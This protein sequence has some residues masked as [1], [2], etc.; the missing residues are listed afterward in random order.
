MSFVNRIAASPLRAKPSAVPTPVVSPPWLLLLCLGVWIGALESSAIASEP[1]PAWTELVRA[2]TSGTVSA[3]SNVR[4]RFIDDV[5]RDS[6]VGESLASGTGQLIQF[7]PPIAGVVRWKSRRELVFEPNER[8]ASGKKYNA[9]LFARGLYGV[10]DA[11]ERFEFS[12]D[13]VEQE[14]TIRFG[15]FAASSDDS[16]IQTFAGSF[17]TTDHV[18]NSAIE[19]MLEGR[20]S[21]RLREAQW[22]HSSDGRKHEFEFAAI[23]RTDREQELVLSWDAR[24][25]GSSGAGERVF[26]VP[27]RGTFDL[28]LVRAVADGSQHI[29]LHFSDRLD[30]KQDL[31]GLI[32]VE[33]SS[34]RAEIEG[35][36]IRVFPADPLVGAVGVTVNGGLRNALGKRLGESEEHRVYF[37]EKHPGVRFAGKGVILPPN[38]KLSIPFEAINVD[39][40]QVTAFRVYDDNMGQFLQHNPLKGGEELD[41]VGRFLWRKTI[42]LGGGAVNEWKR[43]GLDAAPLFADDDDRGGL[44]RLTLSINRGNS[45]YTCSEADLAKEPQVE[46]PFANYEDRNVSERSSW[47]NTENYYSPQAVTWNDWNSPCKDAFFGRNA[48]AK[49][50]RNF[51]VSDLGL[52]AKRGG[53]GTLYLRA[54][55]ISTAVPLAGVEIT[56]FNFQ[57]QVLGVA[58]TDDEGGARIETTGTPFYLEAKHGKEIGY[59]KLNVATSLSTSH[60]EVGGQKVQKGING[61]LYGERG[62]WRP[63][64][65]LNLTFVLFDREGTLPAGHPVTLEL[66][67]PQGQLVERVTNATPVGSFYRFS[68]ATDESAPTGNWSAKARLGGQT[69]AKKIKIEMVVPNRLR[70]ELSFEQ[71][72]LGAPHSTIE[73]V[74]SGQWLHGA[75]ASGLKTDVAVLMR[76]RKTTFASLQDFLFDDP[77]RSVSSSREVLFEGELDS[78]GSVSF[79]KEVTLTERAPGMLSAVFQTRVIEEGGAFSSEMRAFPFHPFN[80]YVGIKTPKGDLARG[81]L[82]TDETHEIEIASVNT[83]GESVDLGKVEVTLYKIDWKWWWDKSGESLAKYI[84]SSSYSPVATGVVETLQGRGRW[85][86]EIK[87]PAWGRYLLRAC[88]ADGGHCTG[89]VI[90]VDWPGWAG[91]AQEEGSSGASSLT[92]SS[93]KPRYSVG[94]TA[95]VVLPAVAQGRAL[96]SIESGSKVLSQRWVEVAEG[97]NRIELPITS[98]MSP[99][100]YVNIVLLQPHRDKV[101]DRPIRLYGYLPVL[102]DDP[103]TMLSP[104]LELPDEVRPESSFDLKVREETGRPM[105]YTLAIV[106]E[107]LLGLTRFQTPNLHKTFYR[108]EALGVRTWDLFDEVTGAYGGELE[109]L[110]ALGGD[111]NE[112]EVEE[113]R[114]KKNRFPPVVKFLGPFRLAP[115]Q[116]AN[117]E[118]DLPPYIG[119]VRVMLVAGEGAAFGS[120]HKSVLVREPLMLLSTVPR[121]LGPDEEIEIPIAVFVGDDSIKQVRLD[122]DA[123]DI[124]EVLSTEG[125]ELE[126]DGPGEKI[127]MLRVRV[128]SRT[129]SGRLHFVASGGQHRAEQTVNL[130]VRSPTP[131]TTRLTRKV[132]AAG[133]KWSSRVTPHGIAGSNQVSVEVSALPPINLADRLDYL[134][135]YPH[136][137]I[138]QVTSAAFPQL[139]LTS[140]VE[141]DESERSRV[142]SNVK[143]AIDRLQPFQ[144]TD[145]GFR[146]WPGSGEA[147]AWATSYAGHFLLEAAKLGYAVPPS[148]LQDWRSYQ[149]RTAQEWGSTNSE[150]VMEQSYRLFT[151]A[152]ANAAEIGAMNRLRETPDL[153][154][155]ARWQLAHAYML[156]GIESAAR[157]LTRWRAVK[158][159]DYTSEGRTFGS[160][161]RDQALVL[162]SLL[163][164]GRE[165]KANDLAEEVSAALAST[166][167]YSTQSTSVA[168]L[169]MA[170]LHGGSADGVRF[171][172]EQTVGSGGKVQIE[173]KAP[174]HR[175]ALDSFPDDGDRVTLRNDSDRA[176][177]VTIMSRGLPTAGSEATENSELKIWVDYF[178]L[179]G[180]EIDPA[181]IE[182]GKD[183]AIEVR[184]RNLTQQKVTNLALTHMIPAGWEIHNARFA[185]DGEAGQTSAGDHQ[186]I[187]DDRVYTYF[188]LKPEEEVEFRLLVNA[189]YLGEFYLPPVSVEAMYDGAKNARIKG[190][191]TKVVGAESDAK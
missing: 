172:F 105:T 89:K 26:A 7:D 166:D 109:R 65:T 56:A 72:E 2:H 183:F 112:E 122:V 171:S 110:L 96:L 168:L 143:A 15:G 76:A 10:P 106:D 138:E 81:M 59:L 43:Y 77:A 24:A 124:F 71:E 14:V 47:D 95:V 99:N 177:Y 18:D 41:R 52:L 145:G 175:R 130:K 29:L 86:F 153:S 27:A 84:A 103:A 141:L 179:D 93:D 16:S 185:F 142:E 69:F 120:T 8:M 9:K 152:L 19:K 129:G 62:V 181:K 42:Q 137:C 162:S 182:Q 128:K 150:F 136:G 32:Q 180:E 83:L 55:S 134:I 111:G 178:D 73:G 161:L 165:S 70:V 92:F 140:L 88:D 12:F 116:S 94:E 169:A 126:F 157:S 91:R 51:L 154:E 61:A 127:G 135:R 40:V 133:E 63:G 149:A 67:N 158:L 98:E 101:S 146:Y 33:G 189:S 75:T 191:W 48:G 28:E 46:S 17:R 36:A 113:E 44:L 6:Q 131:P 30:S 53:D 160:K 159:E 125:L 104:V 54:T 45:L 108:K 74:I 11:L 13:V 23:E 4:V 90:Y 156:A 60:F 82:L 187:R 139:Y 163:S 66:Y 5:A 97:E 119:A 57:G 167:W 151:L 39:A 174:I 31:R 164:L 78:S 87:R 114:K 20:I 132:L 25:I 184:V 35:D 102:V 121:V 118:V 37:S 38:E 100:V 186:D 50:S 85:S 3:T 115:G 1:D 79:A 21:G 49:A 176:L 144:G 147:H 170:S 173:S 155:V 80:N 148:M 68:V 22:E 107:G 117:H 188:D 123:S 64:D 34:H 190:R 58:K